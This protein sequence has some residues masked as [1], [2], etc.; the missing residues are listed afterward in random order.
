MQ[1]TDYCHPQ[2]PLLASRIRLIDSTNLVSE[3]SLN[4]Q[5]IEMIDHGLSLIN[6][7]LFSESIAM[8]D[9]SLKINSSIIN[10][11]YLLNINY[12]D[13]IQNENL[14]NALKE[15]IYF[16][17]TVTTHNLFAAIL[18]KN[19]KK[20]N[21]QILDYLKQYI[22]IHPEDIKGYL[23]LANL[24]LPISSP[25]DKTR[26]DNLTLCNQTLSFFNEF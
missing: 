19:L 7:G 3:Y 4:D 15:I 8:F 25:P 22:Q 12:G 10:L 2:Y 13:S 5:A 9:Q 1:Q 26:P 20:P 21:N 24:Y 11:N 23:Y 18:S 6:A 16:D 17:S 14:L